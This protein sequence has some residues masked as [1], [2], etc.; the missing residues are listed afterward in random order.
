MGLGLFYNDTV[1]LFNRFLD[2]DTGEE[3]YYPTLLKQVNLVE[4]DSAAI[5]KNG[6]TTSDSATLYFYEDYSDKQ[7]VSPKCWEALSDKEKY[8][9]FKPTED[10]FVRGDQTDVVFPA[11]NMYEWMRDNFDSVYKITRID[12]YEDILPHFEVGGV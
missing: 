3:R 1:T 10:F 4:K 5:S 12:K 11:S 9:T 2:P 8:L 7:Y 6:V